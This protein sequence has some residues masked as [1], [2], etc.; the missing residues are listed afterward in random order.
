MPL[1]PERSKDKKTKKKSRAAKESLSNPGSSS[2]SNSKKKTRKDGGGGGGGGKGNRRPTPGY[3]G[4]DGT[5]LHPR[6][7]ASLI[8]FKEATKESSS[9]STV[10]KFLVESSTNE[11]VRFPEDPFEVTFGIFINN[12]THD[13]TQRPP[14]NNAYQNLLGYPAD[15]NP[16]VYINP[17]I[18]GQT[19]F[20]KMDATIDKWAVPGMDSLNDQLWQ[21]QIANRVM[22]S[23]QLRREKYGE[24]YKWISNTGERLVRAAVAGVLPVA[25][26]APNGVLGVL[27]VAAVPAHRHPNLVACQAPLIYENRRQCAWSTVRMGFDS[28]MPMCLQ[29]NALRTIT[30]SVNGTG[31]FHPG[32]TIQISLQQR[33]PLTI[34]LE[35]TDLT[36]DVY[37]Q[38]AAPPAVAVAAIVYTVEISKITLWYES[39]ILEDS[40]ELQKMNA[41]VLEYYV[42][43]PHMRLHELSGGV[44]EHNVP[45]PLPKG[46]RFV[47]IMFLYESQKIPNVVVNS[48]MSGR[49]RFPPG[50]DS[51]QLAMVGREGILFKQGLTGLSTYGGRDS[52]S[53]R[54][55]HS[56]LVKNS[57]YSKSFDEFCPPAGMGIGYDNILALDVTAYHKSFRDLAT[58]KM[59]LRYTTPARANWSVRAFAVTQKLYTY[60]T[61]E[62]WNSKDIV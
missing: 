55:Y 34:C 8:Q 11:I 58:M 38:V 54:Q 13:N 39:F 23:D 15:Q 22:C 1:K 61:K 12:P 52:H 3:K 35:R 6:L 14:A 24:S 37:Y 51:I 59:D 29:N 49:F 17:H 28:L 25:A 41:R 46:T 31:F 10:P 50:L 26:D 53:L 19:F 44:S 7:D 33:T 42:D 21:Y 47:Y 9:I 36:D 43:Y 27:P 48:Y 4:D 30:K 2:S 56:D 18:A 32:A 20:S 62:Q 16:P 60:S 57:L 5:Y 40:M 45:I